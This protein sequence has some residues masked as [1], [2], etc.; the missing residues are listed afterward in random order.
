MLLFIY[1]YQR[2]IIVSTDAPSALPNLDLPLSPSP[3]PTIRFLEPILLYCCPFA[4]IDVCIF[5]VF[6]NFF[7]PPCLGIHQIKLSPSQLLKCFYNPALPTKNKHANMKTRQSADIMC[8]NNFTLPTKNKG[9]TTMKARQS[10]E[11]NLDPQHRAN[12]SQATKI[13]P[14]SWSL[15]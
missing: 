5:C 10:A 3:A 11:T 1:L 12:H 15:Y 7:S 8:F 14:R 6:V 4:L 2:L 13:W 9:K